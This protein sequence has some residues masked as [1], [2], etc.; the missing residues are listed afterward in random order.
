MQIAVYL[1]LRYQKTKGLLKILI[2]SSGQMFY[3]NAVNARTY[4]LV[5]LAIVLIDITFDNRKQHPYRYNLQLLLL[6]QTHIITCGF[7]ASFWII[8]LYELVKDFGI[9][10]AFKKKDAKNRLYGFAIYSLGICWLLAQLS[11]VGV[12]N[13]ITNDAVFI[14]DKIQT[15]ELIQR[16]IVS[17]IL[18]IPNILYNAIESIIYQIVMFKYT[19]Y[20][21]ML[22]LQQIGQSFAI[23]AISVIIAIFLVVHLWNVNK[24]KLVVIFIG[25]MAANMISYYITGL[26]VS[27]LLVVLACIIILQAQENHKLFKTIDYLNKYTFS[28]LT[29]IVIIY[30]LTLASRQIYCTFGL[31][32]AQVKECVKH[33]DDDDTIIMLDERL[34]S[35]ACTVIQNTMKRPFY[36]VMLKDYRTKMS[37]I[38]YEWESYLSDNGKIPKPIEDLQKFVIEQNLNPDNLV[39]PIYIPI[40]VYNDS[41]KKLKIEDT[42]RYKAVKK[43]F[44]TDFK[45]LCDTDS[46]VMQLDGYYIVLLRPND[47]FKNIVNT[48]KGG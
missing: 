25:Q 5:C 31:D 7:I 22:L 6:T 24:Y 43:Y 14:Y 32:S 40:S 8:Q 28:I 33:I 30:G 29:I 11:G 42:I 35:G 15:L 19:P 4:S 26:N 12:Q 38:G 45:V 36:Y 34:D 13:S 2:I 16:F 23:M 44:Y 39:I 9:L 47:T 17:F 48:L 18:S 27:R 37:L 1:F 21:I 41:D 3:Y 20:N 46:F 10:G